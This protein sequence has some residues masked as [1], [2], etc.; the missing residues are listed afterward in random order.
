MDS[1]TP[2]AHTYSYAFALV[3]IPL[4]L[5]GGNSQLDYARRVGG[6]AF[7]ANG[8]NLK[9]AVEWVCDD[10][11]VRFPLRVIRLL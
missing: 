11:Q 5:R 4:F 9:K 8:E 10:F 2:P 1:G 7:V 3:H 6:K